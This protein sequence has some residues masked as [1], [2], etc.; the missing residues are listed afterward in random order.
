[1]KNMFW[2]T[3]FAAA[4]GSD[5][6]AMPDGGPG[7]LP[8]CS[9]KAIESS[10]AFDV[11]LQVVHVTG[12]VTLAGA[13]LP[14]DAAGALEFVEEST[15]VSMTVP[16]AATYDVSLAPGTY[17]IQFVSFQTEG[18]SGSAPCNTGPFEHGI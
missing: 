12:N 13:P 15:R 14:V 18:C 3:L 16:L 17:T 11:D 7:G 9:G 5:A 1:M 8:T 10:G 2:I 6:P 4:C